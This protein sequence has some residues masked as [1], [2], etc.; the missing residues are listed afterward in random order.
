[1]SC[2][3]QREDICAFNKC[4]N[5]AECGWYRLQCMLDK[6]DGLCFNCQVHRHSFAKLYKR[7]NC[8]SCGM[9][10]RRFPRK[11]HP[12]QFRCKRNTC[13]ADWH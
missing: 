1:M 11:A 3:C 7:N 9:P 2:A 5:F 4:R 12:Q 13:E 10:C 8:L 6:A